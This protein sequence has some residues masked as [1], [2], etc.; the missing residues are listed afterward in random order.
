MPLWKQS[1]Y[2][3]RIIVYTVIGKYIIKRCSKESILNFAKDL[4][5][6]LQGYDRNK[7]KKDLTEEE[8]NKLDEDINRL[9]VIKSWTSELYIVYKNYNSDKCYWYKEI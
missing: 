5:K 1:S 6:N 9:K 4:I 3:E 8:L 7:L 2:N